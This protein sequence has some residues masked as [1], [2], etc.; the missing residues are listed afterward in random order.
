MLLPLAKKRKRIEETIRRKQLEEIEETEEEQEGE[1]EEDGPSATGKTLDVSSIQSQIKKLLKYSTFE[2]EHHYWLNTGSVDLNS[3]L[4]SKKLGIPYGKLFELNGLEHGGK[5][6]IATI[7]LGMAQRDGAAGGC[8]DL[9]QSRDKPW[10]TKL[11]ADFEN[12]FYIYPKLIFAK[13]KKKK[14][15]DPSPKKSEDEEDKGSKKIPRLQSA[16]ECF[17]E[18]EVAMRMFQEQGYD[19]Q[20]WIVDSI[21]NIQPLKM[22]EA[23]VTDQ[24]MNTRMA[25]AA[26]LANMLPRW[27]GLAA[28]YNAIVLLINQLTLKQGL[29]FGDPYDSVGGRALRT[30]CSIRARVTRKGKPLKHNDIVIGIAGTIRNIKNK[31]G[32]GSVESQKAGFKILWSANPARVKFMTAKEVKSESEEE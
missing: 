31:A 15:Y 29:V 8:V 12:T 7:L 6:D 25:R 17:A 30:N 9:E 32:G 13:K 21:A 24:T 14:G 27:A 1:V 10:A 3:V 20:C 19:K 5:T 26:F 22:V 28:N 4:G 18:A 23:G 11:G 16:E 2:P